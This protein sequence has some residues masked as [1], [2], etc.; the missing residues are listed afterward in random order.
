MRNN[1]PYDNRRSNRA[2]SYRNNKSNRSNR[3][4][5]HA[6]TENIKA[7]K[8]INKATAKIDE[9]PYE[10]T[11]TFKDFGFNEKLLNNLEHLNYVKP[12]EIQDQTIKIALNG[13]DVIG[14][15]NTGTGKTAAFLLPIIE[16]LSYGAKPASVLILAPT[17][18]LANQ[19]DQEFK[20]FSAGLRLYSTL[21]V[22]GANIGRQ[23]GQIKRGPHIFIGTPGRV[24]DLIE[25]K[26]LRLA[27]VSHFVLDEADRM[28]DMGFINDIKQ[29]ASE[30][31]KSKQ[32]FCFSATMT[33]NVKVIV[34]EFMNKPVTVSVV[35]N[36]TNNHIEQDVVYYNDTNH[37]LELLLDLLKKPDF[38]KV[39]IFGGTKFGVQRL[40]D[41][42]N[43]EGLRS[44]AIHGNKSQSQRER[45]LRQFKEGKTNILIATDVAARGLDIPNVSHVINFDEPQ[46]YADYVHRIGRTGRAGKSGTA[47]TFVH[48]GGKKY[49]RDTEDRKDSKP[50]RERN[51]KS[52]RSS[53]RNSRSDNRQNRDNKRSN[54]RND[55][56]FKQDNRPAKRGKF[57]K[58]SQSDKQPKKRYVGMTE[59]AEQRL[60]D[61]LND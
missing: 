20:S 10:A 33:K 37:R 48:K 4:R 61:L 25:R 36:E 29:I 53:S 41:R 58:K 17:R 23:I 52:E 12:S 51:S 39:I 46:A 3:T 32:T 28:C 47:L 45:A 54:K 26:I 21:L 14:L 6:K 13:E 38:D 19:I 7:E 56:D 15:A 55:R 35:K 42:I 27:Q 49:V 8:Y 34:E 60:L 11:H 16:H 50:R 43:E 2:S 5:N 1:K 22:G 40:S 44:T 57:S 31:S 24:K 59:K 18:E 30:L 9:I